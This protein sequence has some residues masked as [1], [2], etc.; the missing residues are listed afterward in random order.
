MVCTFIFMGQGLMAQCNFGSLSFSAGGPQTK[1]Y[2]I[3][4]CSGS[5]AIFTQA[6][7]PSWITGYSVNFN[8]ITITVTA[9]TG[10]ARNFG[11]GIL[12]NGSQFPVGTLNISQSAG[13][14][15]PSCTVSSSIGSSNFNGDGEEKTFPLTY[16]NCSQQYNFTFTTSGGGALPNWVDITK[17]GTNEIKIRANANTTSG[18]RSVTIIG[19]AIG[20]SSVSI[21][22]QITQSCNLRTWYRDKDGDGY[23][24]S[25]VTQ[26]S[27]PT[28]TSYYTTEVLP[29]GD[30]DDDVAAINPTTVWYPDADNDN[31]RDPNGTSQQGCTKPSGNWT[32]TPE[33]VVDAC[34]QQ[35]AAAPMSSNGCDPDCASGYLR[36][37]GTSAG[38]PA[39]TNIP[40][41]FSFSESGGTAWVELVFP[42]GSCATPYDPVFE[43]VP[44]W[45]T[46]T[47]ESGNR[48]KIVCPTYTT[49]GGERRTLPPIKVKVVNNVF[50]GNIS[51][52]QDG[53][54]LPCTVSGSLAGTFS[55]NGEELTFPLTYNNCSGQ[56]TTYDI[57]KADGSALPNWATVTKNGPDEIK[58]RLDRN[59]GQSSRTITVVGTGITD[60]SLSVGGQL[61]QSCNLQT[62]YKDKDNDGWADFA[63]DECSQPT[64][65][66][67]YKLSVNGT[68]D[69]DDDDP[70]V[71]PGT[72]W[73]EDTDGDNY[74]DENGA[75]QSGCT[76]PATGNWTNAP[77]SVDDQCP[78]Q[79]APGPGTNG[80]D[81]DCAQ[82]YLRELNSGA[83]PPTPPDP[84]QALSFTYGE[85]GGSTTVEVAFPSA[86]SCSPGYE[87]F[88][89]GP[90]A[91]WASFTLNPDNTISVSVGNFVS[92]NGSSSNSTGSR[93]F[94]N[95]THIGILSVTQNGPPV[96]PTCTVIVE[97]DGVAQ[98]FGEDINY[99]INADTKVVDISFDP[100]SP[101]TEDVSIVDAQTGSD[102]PFWLDTPLVTT[103]K[104]NFTTL[105]NNTGQSRTAYIGVQNAQGDILHVFRVYQISCMDQEWYPDQDGDGVGDVTAVPRYGCTAPT[106]ET[107]GFVNNNTDLCPLVFG[108]DQGCPV[109][110]APE[111]RNTVTTLNYDLNEQLKVGTKAYFDEIGKLE[112]T[113]TW[114]VR[115]DSIWASATLYEEF[116]RPAL[117]TLSAPIYEGSSFLYKEGFIKKNDD[118]T[119][120]ALQDFDG[121]NS[122]NPEP[123]G[124]APETLGWYYSSSNDHEAYQDVTA[125]PFSKHIFSDLNPG[126]TL[127]TVGGNQIDGQWPQTYTFSMLASEELAQTP[128]FGSTDYNSVEITK[129]V[130][131][132][133]HGVEN[134]VFT[135]SDG[136]VLAAARSGSDGSE[137]TPMNV[138]IPEQG[139]VDIH[140]AEGITGFSISNSAAVTVYNLIT[141]ASIGTATTTLGNGFYRVAVNDLEGY[142]PGSI[143]VG[144]TV[145]YYD[146]SLNEY[147]EADRLVASYQPLGNTKAQKPLTTYEYNTLGQLIE[148][149]SPDEGQAWFK[150]REDGQIRFSQNSKQ[151]DPNEDGNFDDAEFSYTNYDGY[152]RP[153]ESGVFK[154]GTITFANSNTLLE[155]VLE[156]IS[157]DDD[158]LT[159]ANCSE[160]QFTLYDEQDTAGLHASLTASSIPTTHYS[161]QRFVRGNVSKTYTIDSNVATTTW[162][163]YDVYGRV[164][165]MV[166]QI[167]GLGTKTLDYTYDPV[168]GLVQKVYYQKEVAAERFIHRYGYNVS[169]QLITVET[170]TDDSNFTVHANYTYYETG[171]MKRTAL[172]PDAQGNPAQG[173]DYVY[174][175]AGQL[176]SLNH[177]SLESASDPG[178]DTNDLFGMQLDY[179]PN[180]YMRPN[181]PN[182][183]PQIYGQNQLNG[184]IKGIRWK[185]DAVP[186]STSELR[187]AYGYDR[188]NWLTSAD[189]DGTGSTGSGNGIVSIAV[190][191][192]GETLVLED[193]NSITLSANNGT[194]GFHAK[195]GSDVTVRI[196]SGSGGG[197][198]MAG[199]YDVS[200]L[201]YDANG[202]LL[203]LRRNK[204]SDGTG[205]AMDDLSYTYESG[206]NQLLQVT[207]AEGDVA[208][209]DDIGTQSDTNNYVYNVIGQLIENK[210]EMITYSYNTAGLVTEIKRNGL[211]LV[212]F[213]YNDRNHRVR[214]DTYD[215][216]GMNVAQTTH[217]VRDAVGSIIAVYANTALTEQPI[218]GND[219]LG[220]HFR[221]DGTDVYE[222]TD[223]LGNVRATFA[224]TGNDPDTRSGSDYYPF[225]MPMPG[226]NIVGDYRY[227]FQ[228][229]EK[230]P[231]TGMEAF[232]LRLWD[233]RIGRWLTTDPAGQYSSPYLGMGNN[234]INGVDP[235]GGKFLDD[236]KLNKDG[237]L[238]LIAET[239][240]ADRIFNEGGDFV[241]LEYDGQIKIDGFGKLTESL[242]FNNIELST[243]VFEFVSFFSEVEWAQIIDND[244]NGYVGT[245]YDKTSVKEGNNILRGL[246][247]SGKRGTFI[248]RHSHPR[249][250][251]EILGKALGLI[252]FDQ[253][254]SD[255]D[256]NAAEF[257]VNKIN[258]AGI[259]DISIKFQVYDAVHN[260]YHNYSHRG[261]LRP[262]EITPR[263]VKL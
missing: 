48:I 38:P 237:S 201:S 192:S 118:L 93:I 199:D 179:H 2:T 132:D 112:Q 9:N 26:C 123:V 139:F 111:N 107:Y 141:E 25:Q 115:S 212:T 238:T 169:D 259:D 74:K 56:T 124:D 53:P 82:G 151:K 36:E 50:I 37:D 211:S 106:D 90:V 120:Y 69:C 88:I 261:Y 245:S 134:V 232:E 86:V 142:V 52:V 60:S 173:I 207:D 31:F 202:N 138:A 10:S 154:E 248:K 84:Y 240:F 213:F 191:N 110:T 236:Y 186:G 235:D 254:P 153:V 65:T 100:V 140:I 54:P 196:V 230:D 79:S 6:P 217:Y 136:K 181:T 44:G 58:I 193:E 63:V 104:F 205:N 197:T 170:S 3:T 32:R 216:S 97:V 76:P 145:N 71:H 243:E 185:N 150:Y 143:T 49:Q 128:A 175:L 164:E 117:Q 188:N 34:P 35:S 210:E 147:D 103:N 194:D 8:Q 148:T 83:L 263:G 163:S 19:T 249:S 155:N 59:D 30:C 166:Q 29:L 172:A 41:E 159:D 221:Q 42:N 51:V 231:E 168:T 1:T 105:D 223:H 94:V 157:I 244:V 165:W 13:G 252:N 121:T 233:A 255:N 20:N 14:P 122:E 17:N 220:V 184:N 66:A 156:D 101:C 126:K 209:A 67:W 119:N 200:N 102:L 262:V 46:L 125:Y 218:Y 99:G 190:V 160:Q 5:F 62:W 39:S 226:R 57:K 127:R 215:G 177:P 47:H 131:R 113:Q 242:K 152:G 98:P 225:G 64:P 87:V 146:Y 130:T 180:D 144:Y 195:A 23:A 18:S 214:K 78:N 257:F 162:Y 174:N 219:R 114:D 187:Y 251:R 158:G 21:G 208:N 89:E 72:T 43:D 250:E 16:S 183:T 234:P 135:D 137:S 80:C 247:N 95:G 189:F 228:G 198:L 22:G 204:G 12:Q 28:P 85:Q 241:Q 61:T 11:M 116:G 129:T 246:I 167:A 92:I 96:P 77:E 27:S 149:Q 15:P 70:L 45:L 253:S 4:S 176:K 108:S 133:V 260:A 171:A 24:A 73:Y 81:S 68:G 229:Q 7:I 206:T 178:G 91:D 109:G 256:V 203:S 222:L 258:E 75:T 239:D 182:I 227:A 224:K 161:E 33:T 40:V 55:E